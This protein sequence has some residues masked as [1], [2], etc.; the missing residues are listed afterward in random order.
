MLAPAPAAGV[1]AA[2]TIDRQA[3]VPEHE[4]DRAAC[5]RDEKAPRGDED[6]RHCGG[7]YAVSERV[8]YRSGRLGR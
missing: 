6:E 5:D 3:D 4:P 2:K 8:R 1:A 7:R